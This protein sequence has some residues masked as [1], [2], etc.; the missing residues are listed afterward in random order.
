M[1][2][3]NC[4][5]DEVRGVWDA[6]GRL[7]GVLGQSGKVLDIA[8]RPLS[9]SGVAHPFTHL[10]ATVTN[11]GTGNTLYL[12][13]QAKRAFYGHRAIYANYDTASYDVGAAISA[14]APT[15]ANVGNTLTWNP[16]TY[17]GAASFTV[18]AG[19][20]GVGAAAKDAIPSIIRCDPIYLA[21]LARTDTPGAKPLVQFRTFLP[22]TGKHSVHLG[23][24]L[25]EAATGEQWGAR[26]PNAGNAVA[27]PAGTSVAPLRAGLYMVPQGVEFMYDAPTVTI[28]DAGDSLLRCQESD[29]DTGWNPMSNRIAARRNAAGSAAIWTPMSMAVTGQILSSSMETA[30]RLI[31]AVRPNFLMVRAWSPND[32]AITQAKIDEAWAR[33][34]DVLEEAR[35]VGTE[36]VVLTTPP[37]NNNNPAQDALLKVQNARVLGLRGHKL[38]ADIASV[39][40]DPLD[41]SKWRAEYTVDSGLHCPNAG[42]VAM[43]AVIDETIP[44]Y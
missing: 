23:F 21:S 12:Q 40:E 10:V 33:L 20:A 37:N 44:A 42:Y 16:V 1:K 39:V 3:E 7:V 43:E 32:G 28:A 17:G 18:P 24:A 11:G 4:S 29:T 8:R 6:A 15:D 25:H 30:K 36:V 9:A 35:R 27:V 41:R 34:M 22:N 14:M 2:L 19:T 38:V 31:N 5:V 13:A 26:G